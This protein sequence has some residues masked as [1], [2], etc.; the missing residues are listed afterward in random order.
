MTFVWIPLESSLYSSYFQPT[1]LMS[2][3]LCHYLNQG[4][5]LK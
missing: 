2:Q 1:C 5:T 3:E 4:R